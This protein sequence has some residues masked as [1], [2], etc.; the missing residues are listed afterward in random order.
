M[1]NKKEVLRKSLLVGVGVATYT[2]EK[3]DKLVSDL[4]KKE[5]ISKSEGKKLVNSVVTEA[6][7][8]G[9]RVAD[10]L[11]TELKKVM[12]TMAMKNS[13]CSSCKPMK[14]KSAKKKKR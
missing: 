2:K 3:T 9:K 1:V 7:K 11:E 14:K 13:S 5:H 10:V 4:L 8:S 6:Q 12:R